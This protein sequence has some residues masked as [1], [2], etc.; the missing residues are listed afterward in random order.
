VCYPHPDVVQCNK[1]YSEIRIGY[2]IGYVSVH[3]TSSLCP[4]DYC[5]FTKCEE[6]SPGYFELPSKVD[7]QCSS[8]RT[9]VACGK[10]VSGYTLSYDSPNCI[11]IDNCSAG[12]TVLVVVLTIIY[13]I[14]VV[15]VVFGVMYFNNRVLSGYVYG[16]A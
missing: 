13:W 11:N 7:E 10:C 3:Y 2:W 4:N 1:D 6:S 14:V 9:G 12:M 5:N 8:H 16:I 15:T